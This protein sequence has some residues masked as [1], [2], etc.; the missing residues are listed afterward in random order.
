MAT[1]TATF[2]TYPYLW[3]HALV[4]RHQRL[5]VSI[6]PLKLKARIAPLLLLVP[7]T[8][9]CAPSAEAQ[10]GGRSW[11]RRAPKFAAA[12]DLAAG[13]FTFC[14][15][16]Y[17]SVRSEALGHGWNTDYPESDIHFMVRLSQLTQ[18]EVNEYDDGEPNHVVVRPT[19]DEIYGC[20]F[21]FMS[22]VGTVG[23]SGPEVESLRTYLLSG[24]F[25]YVD[26]FWGER[27]WNHWSREIG[28]VLPPAEF[29]IV[30]VPLEH[31][32]FRGLY[33]IR[34]IPQV[35]SIQH[36]RWTGET[37]ERGWESEEPHVRGIFDESGR[38]MVVMTHNTDI[39]DGWE[40]EGEDEEF[41]ARFSATKAY[42]MGIN[43]VLYA[44]TH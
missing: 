41:F 15:L 28:K 11:H 36:W 21:I 10:W 33:L 29:P 44:M 38:L 31:E 6:A 9:L 2:G 8:W 1:N 12:E 3:P 25:L 34:E 19:D 32:L 5:P 24:G 13:A 39:A 4:L 30:D 17:N 20:P 40:R 23:F 43:I 16:Y 14:R 37:S 35:P 26:D 18:V 42:P 27:A 22:D 7:A